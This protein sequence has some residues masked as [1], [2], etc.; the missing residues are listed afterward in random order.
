MIVHAIISFHGR[1]AQCS[2]KADSAR[3]IQNELV[4]GG[5]SLRLKLDDLASVAVDEELP[6][7]ELG[8]KQVAGQYAAA[9]ALVRDLVNTGAGDLGPAELEMAAEKL[10]PLREDL[11]SALLAELDLPPCE[12]GV[13]ILKRSIAREKAPKVTVNGSLATLAALRRRDHTGV[14]ECIELA[15]AEN[16]L[17]NPGTRDAFDLQ[18]E[19]DAI[20]DLYGRGHRGQWPAAGRCHPGLGP[21]RSHPSPG[22]AGRPGRCAQQRVRRPSHGQAHALPGRDQLQQLL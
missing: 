10:A 15:Q 8:A 21:G 4:R 11:R 6:A 3:L 13:L 1:D 12:D 22:Q 2:V 9:T 17:T 7:I 5:T 19:P 18:R 16:L 14:G 20:K